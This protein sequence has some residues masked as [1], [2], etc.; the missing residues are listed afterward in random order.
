MAS[1]CREDASADVN[2]DAST[3]KILLPKIW[4]MAC[5]SAANCGVS[6]KNCTACFRIGPPPSWHE[7]V[8]EMGRVDRS[9][10]CEAGSN[11]YN[12]YLNLNNF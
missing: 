5:T 1:C 6:S 2:K 12:I 9:H 4:C 10:N 3:N 8:Q 11:T 7:M